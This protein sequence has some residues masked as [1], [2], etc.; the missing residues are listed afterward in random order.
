MVM[1]ALAVDEAFLGR[2]WCASS[3]FGKPSCFRV[4]YDG[5]TEGGVIS[6]KGY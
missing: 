2:R 4:N 3:A 5:I 1:F 6:K